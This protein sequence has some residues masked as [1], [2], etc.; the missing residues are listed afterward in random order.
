[1]GFLERRG[2]GA[3]THVLVTGGAGY[4]GS[5]LC[6]RLLDAGCRVT[7]LDNLM[8]GRHTLFH[9]RANPSFSF[10]FGDAR[11]ESLIR[12]Q[13]TSADVIIPLAAVVGAPACDRDPRSCLGG[14]P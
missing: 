6:E 5:I 12:K 9:L 11:D 10:V 13:I 8:Y 7:A 2:R 14:V 3:L 1:L 4:P